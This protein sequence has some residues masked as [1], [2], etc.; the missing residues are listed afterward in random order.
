[1]QKKV[2]ISFMELAETTFYQAMNQGA[3]G[4]GACACGACSNCSN[5]SNNCN[6]NCSA[7][8]SN[9]ACSNNCV[10]VCS[11]SICSSGK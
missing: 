2:S 4:G 1:M 7:C 5:C 11:I 9:C 6:S 10:S 8:N 3:C